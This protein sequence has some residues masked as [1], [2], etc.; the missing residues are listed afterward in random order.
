MRYI[1]DPESRI[2]W[3]PKENTL[4]TTLQEH[5]LSVNQ[6]AVSQD[7]MFFVSGSNDQTVK[8]W[9]TAGIDQLAIP[10]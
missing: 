6:L 7:Q 2:N 10:M 8:I 5:C 4:V 1:G 9:K 3:R